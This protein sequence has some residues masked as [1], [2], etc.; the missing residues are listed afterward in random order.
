MKPLILALLCVPAFADVFEVPCTVSV[1]DRTIE[2]HAFKSLSVISG[3]RILFHRM[4][5]PGATLREGR[6]R[7]RR[8][9][10]SGIMYYFSYRN[11]VYREHHWTYGWPPLPHKEWVTVEISSN[12][13]NVTALAKRDPQTGDTLRCV[14]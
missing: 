4:F 7:E 8:Y 6:G 5:R 9:G 13:M 14:F 2:G 1:E 12:Y 11:G 3:S 10:E